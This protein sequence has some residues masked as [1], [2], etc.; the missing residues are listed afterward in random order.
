MSYQCILATDG[1]I[2]FAIFLYDNT[3]S[4][5]VDIF[6]QI[7]FNENTEEYHI[8]LQLGQRGSLQFPEKHAF[9]IDG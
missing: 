6:R 4:I 2:S 7:G 1:D 8:V 5:A 3:E 9:R